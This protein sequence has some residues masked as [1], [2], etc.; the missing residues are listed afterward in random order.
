MKDWPPIIRNFY[1]QNGVTDIWLGEPATD[2]SITEFERAMHLKVSE[3]FRSLYRQCDGT[4]EVSDKAAN[5]Y[6]GFVSIQR[7]P[8]FIEEVRRSFRDEHPVE[9][10][11]FF[12]FFDRS[13]RGDLN[14]LGF[15]YSDALGLDSELYLFWRGGHDGKT[16]FLLPCEE[17]IEAY[18]LA[19]DPRSEQ[20]GGCDGEKLRS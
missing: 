10:G 12:P 20:V 18:L 4:N 3:E 11:N 5:A 9:A 8:S 15:M 7:L 19:D 1:A 2:Q 17:S 14:V 6:F 16:V 13:D